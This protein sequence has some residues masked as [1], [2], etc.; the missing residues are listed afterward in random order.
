MPTILAI[1]ISYIGILTVFVQAILA[2]M[3]VTEIKL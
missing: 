1:Q 2:F 3:G